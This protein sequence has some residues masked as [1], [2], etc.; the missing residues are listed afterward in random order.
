MWGYTFPK[1]NSQEG[2]FIKYTHPTQLAQFLLVFG[3]S[4]N[5]IQCIGY[6]F[7]HHEIHVIIVGDEFTPKLLN[8]TLAN[9]RLFDH[10][11]RVFSQ[12]ACNNGL[13]YDAI[14]ILIM[15]PFSIFHKQIQRLIN[16]YFQFDLF[17]RLSDLSN[18]LLLFHPPCTSIVLYLFFY[19]TS[20]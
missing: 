7:L 14:T 6:P 3:V 16:K 8:N 2:C 12:L 10:R 18:N 5:L 19:T 11:E 17:V 4:D 9:E 15:A 20:N 13:N 1:V